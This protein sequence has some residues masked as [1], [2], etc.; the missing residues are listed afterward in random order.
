MDKFIK[1]LLAGIVAGF[2]LFLVASVS[3][4]FTG[5]IS[6]PS[7]SS[8]F[9]E[10]IS[11]KWFYK[12]LLLNVGMGVIMAVFYALLAKGMPG[13]SLVKGMFWGFVVWAILIAQPLIMSLVVGKFTSDMLLS[14]L[15]QGLVSY[16]CAGLGISLIYKE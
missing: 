3:Y 5:K 4:N 7:L 11:M 12:L 13:T 10:A 15:A 8:L 16:V 9:R 2:I 1:M 14:W 6:D